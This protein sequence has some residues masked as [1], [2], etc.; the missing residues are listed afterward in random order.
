MGSQKNRTP[1]V[2]TT[3]NPR[4]NASMQFLVKDL[5]DDVLCI[6]VFALG[7]FCPNGE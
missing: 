1:T 3:A 2:M 7:R 5:E 4:W 6:T